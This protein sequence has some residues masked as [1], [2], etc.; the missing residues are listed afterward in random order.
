VLG[1]FLRRGFE[2]FTDHARFEP[3]VPGSVVDNGNLSARL[4]KQAHRLRVVA[5]LDT[6]LGQ[7]GVG[8]PFDFAQAFFIQQIVSWDMALDVRRHQVAIRRGIALTQARAGTASARFTDVS[9]FACGHLNQPPW[10]NLPSPD[11]DRVPAHCQFYRYRRRAEKREH[12][13]LQ[14][15]RHQDSEKPG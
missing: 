9:F 8:R 1:K 6:D 5:K 10:L 2:N 3:D 15:V 7:D 12:W 4:L 14:P 13:T 11:Q